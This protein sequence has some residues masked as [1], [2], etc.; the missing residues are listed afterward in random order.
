MA[1]LNGTSFVAVASILDD[2]T[3]VGSDHTISKLDARPIPVNDVVIH[4]VKP[5]RCPVG[6]V[7]HKRTTA[8]PEAKLKIFAVSVIGGRIVFKKYCHQIRSGVG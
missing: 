7:T 2:I 8:V 4:V 3:G 6:V 1:P 5:L